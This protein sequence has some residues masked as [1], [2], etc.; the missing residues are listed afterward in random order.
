[1]RSIARFIALSALVGGSAAGGCANE[2]FLG[3]ETDGGAGKSSGG[4][5]AI[6]GSSSGG[7]PVST[8]GTGGALCGGQVC[9]SS[10]VCCGPAE[11]GHCISA[12][13]GQAC[14]AT[15][16]TGGQGPAGTGGA[17]SS[18]GTPSAGAGGG[19][20]GGQV[21]AADQ[22]CCGPAQCGHC[23]PALSGQACPTTCGTGGQGAG[24]T[25]GIGGSGGLCG[26]QVCPSGQVCCGPPQCGICV[27]AG[28]DIACP[29]VCVATG[30]TGAGGAST[31]KGGT[32]S[33]GAGG[34]ATCVAQ[35]G[36]CSSGETCCSGLTCCSGMPVQPG[37]EYCSNICP[38][39]D[40]NLKTA[41]EPVNEDSVLERLMTLPVSTWSYRSEGTGVRH[42][43]PM[44]QDFQAAFGLGASDRT[45]LQVDGDGVALAAIQALGRKF[46]KLS[47]EN[48]QLR[49]RVRQLEEQAG[50]CGQWQD[51]ATSQ[52]AHESRGNSHIR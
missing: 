15:C 12:L 47:A 18:G 36:S 24:G 44:A 29:T 7:A 25:G 6:G 33:T 1:M 14:P 28:S 51:S 50:T 31:A 17:T 5:G 32:P 45:I 23:I 52:P 2:N 19:P 27:Y 20:C 35:Q 43:G 30:G 13:S 34:S 39:S 22:V 21:C 10:Q 9:G 11:C 16:G 41:I 46:E 42:L 3:T 38:V 26:S 49:Q 48:A 37:Q 8:A 40:R 4:A